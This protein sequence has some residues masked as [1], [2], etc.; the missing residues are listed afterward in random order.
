MN[1]INKRNSSSN[2]V[3]FSALLF[4]VLMTFISITALKVFAATSPT[5]SGSSGYSVLGG[6]AITNTG[7]TTT[8]GAVGVSPGTS[9]GGGITAGGGIHSNDASAIAA[10]A[11]NLAAFSTIDQGCEFPA[12]QFGAGV[13]D[14]V[15]ANLVPGVYC[16]DAFT[17]SG[18]LTL[19]GSGVWIFKSAS[20][21]ITSGTANV[22]GGDPCNVWWRVG[23]SATLGTSTSLIGNILALNGVNAMNT[24]AT[25]NGRLL[26]QAAGTITLDSNTINGPVCA[27]TPSPR[28]SASPSPSSSPT[29]TATPTATPSVSPSATPTDTSS[30]TATPTETLTSEATSTPTPTATP[31]ITATPSSTPTPTETTTST[32]TTKNE[33]SQ[34]VSNNSQSNSS[35]SGTTGTSTQVLGASTM[36]KTGSFAELSNMIIM[37]LGGTLSVFGIKNLKKVSKKA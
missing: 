21:L 16:A 37:T 32:T 36:A 34:G 17:L 28:P 11:D 25:L 26:V 9:I 24:G 6:A 22:V 29:A 15:G 30:P 2:K 7:T 13:V 23:S 20:T 18:T 8:N 27:A 1:I 35:T 31:E 12:Y 5:L 33:T 4:I 3:K 10:Q 19:S 14:L